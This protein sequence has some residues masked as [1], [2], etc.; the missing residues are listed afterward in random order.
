MILFI[1]EGKRR[2]PHLFKTL[3]Y[4]FFPIDEHPIVYSYGN[5][6]YE[7]YKEL[8]MLDEAGD[9]VSILREKAQNEESNPLKDFSMTSDFSEI[10][11]FFDYDIQNKNLS[12]QQMNMQIQEMLHYFN[13]ETNNGKLYINY[14]MI[15]SIRC[16]NKL[17]DNDYYKYTVKKE[18]CHHFKNYAT[19]HYPYYKTFDFLTFRTDS[20]TNVI[21]VPTKKKTMKLSQIGCS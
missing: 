17:P 8:S 18:D 2:E 16:T 14:P 20:K 1:F 6:I 4:L 21:V 15:E 5:N 7:L 19:Q 9:I 3:E 10:F 11:L 13:N 12:V